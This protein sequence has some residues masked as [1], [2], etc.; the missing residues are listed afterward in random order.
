MNDVRDEYKVYIV[1]SYEDVQ[2]L[3]PNLSNEEAINALNKVKRTLKER[4]TEEG[5]EILET[6]LE[7][8]GYETKEIN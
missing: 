5:W 2:T 3:S 6:A 7:M 1:W 8:H 4:S